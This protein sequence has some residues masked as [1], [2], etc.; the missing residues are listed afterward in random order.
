MSIPYQSHACIFGII[1]HVI[2]F[3]HKMERPSSLDVLPSFALYLEVNKEANPFF[4]TPASELEV[5]VIVIR[6]VLRQNPDERLHWQPR[7]DRI[8]KKPKDA[9]KKGSN[10]GSNRC[11]H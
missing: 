2:N 4:W 3:D 8:Q 11:P 10:T 1:L 6:S 5:L 7:R 9:R